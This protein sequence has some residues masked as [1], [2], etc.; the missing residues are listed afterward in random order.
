MAKLDALTWVTSKPSVPVAEEV[1]VNQ[2]SPELGYA[3]QGGGPTITEVPVA[4]DVLALNVVQAGPSAGNTNAAAGA[5]QLAMFGLHEAA[6]TTE[7]GLSPAGGQP[8]V[9]HSMLINADRAGLF[10]QLTPD[11]SNSRMK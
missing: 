6:G 7:H 10:T 5:G 3:P 9:V 2:M 11:A 4:P 8:E 1:A